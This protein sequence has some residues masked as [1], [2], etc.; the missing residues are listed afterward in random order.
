MCNRFWTNERAC[1]T[2]TI[3]HYALDCDTLDGTFAGR[4]GDN[5]AMEFSGVDQ[6][7]NWSAVFNGSN[8]IE[9]WIESV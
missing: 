6:A 9:V 3:A 8:Y 4:H 2:A 1:L 7:K 5:Y